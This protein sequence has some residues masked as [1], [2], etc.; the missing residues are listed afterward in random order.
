MAKLRPKIVCIGAGSAVFGLSNLATIV[1]SERLRGSEIVL[2]DIDEAGLETMT[3]AGPAHERVVGRADED[4]E[5]HRARGS[6]ARRRFRR[7][8]GAGR[9]PRGRLGAGLADPAA[10]R[11]APALRREQR[12]RRPGPHRPQRA[13]DP[14]HRPGH[15]APLPR[16]LVPQLYQPHDPPDLGGQALHQDQGR[17]PVPPALLGLRHGRRRPGRPLGAGLSRRL[18][19]PHQL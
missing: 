5:H 16:G 13:P 6:P 11:R 18:S 12:P 3:Q 8:L 1:R 7:R 10:A 9:P 14:G 15:G 4:L 17:G 2:V 19:R